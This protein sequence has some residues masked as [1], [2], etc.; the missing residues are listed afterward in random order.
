MNTH[1][2]GVLAWNRVRQQLR[3][4]SS[5]TI[6]KSRGLA[7]PR[8]AGARLT[9]SWP[10]GQL[11]DYALD[12]PG[13]APLLIREFADRYE[14]A[15]VGIKLAE[16]AMTLVEENPKAALYVG[17]TL[18]GATFG[19]LTRQRNGVLAGAAIGALAALVL[20]GLSSQPPPSS[21]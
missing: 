2:D 18:L 9:L 12:L 5:L 8:N 16:Q 19:A 21:E 6:S 3:P 15:L 20:H 14:T 17:S 1:P 4:G 7:H 11:A 13:A 10:V